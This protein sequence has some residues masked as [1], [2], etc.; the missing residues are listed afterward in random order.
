MIYWLLLVSGILLFYLAFRKIPLSEFRA[1]L[2]TVDPIWLL[3]LLVP[4]WGGQ[5][6]RTWR[7]RLLFGDQKPPFRETYHSL[8]LGYFVNLALPRVGELSRCA[9]LQSV[10]GTPFARSLGTV[11]VERLTDIAMLVLVALTAFSLQGDTIRQVWRDHIFIPL[12]SLMT[13]KAALLTGIGITGLI[14][15][16]LVLYY[17]KRLWAWLDSRSRGFSGQI[18]QGLS[19]VLH[20]GG[21]DLLLFILLSLGIW[22][23]YFCTTWFWF[24]ALPAA[25]SATLASAFTVMVVSSLVKTLPIQG[26]GIGAYHYIIG[27]L[28]VLYGL[29]EVSSVTFALLNHG[30][31]TCFYLLFGGFSAFWIAWKKKK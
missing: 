1:E 5:F 30:Y 4:S 6:L 24:L 19:G 17:R 18:M 28:L 14:G 7:W 22:M 16:A 12:S 25:H 21:K 20:L 23:G 11:V 3:F 26:G 13:D 2:R 9:A 8:L 10:S 29:S 15:F 31:Q 27:H